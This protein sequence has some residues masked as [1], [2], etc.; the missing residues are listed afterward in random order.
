MGGLQEGERAAEDARGRRDGVLGRR[1]DALRKPRGGKPI[2]G[3][4][5]YGT[6]A[7][8]AD[9]GEEAGGQAGGDDRRTAW[10]TRGEARRA[11]E[12]A[13]EQANAVGAS[14]ISDSQRTAAGLAYSL[15]ARRGHGRIV[16][17][18]VGGDQ[19]V[20][21]SDHRRGIHSPLRSCK[22]GAHRRRRAGSGCGCD[23]RRG[24][25][26]ASA[27]ARGGVAATPGHAT[28]AAARGLGGR[29]RADARRYAA[30]QSLT[31][32]P[33]VVALTA[34]LAPGL[35]WNHD[36]MPPQLLL[37]G[38]RRSASCRHRRPGRPAAR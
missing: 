32:D 28:H 27:S 24:L 33:R 23:R 18:Q 15:E 29:V 7:D 21:P 14:R 25:V 37:T 19:G 4:D 17:R 35:S 30:T 38:R 13:A 10:K 5:P 16:A 31:W 11:R 26:G 9:D 2:G 34:C 36:Q 6:P 1:R 12:E 8:P 22:H 3:E 20:S